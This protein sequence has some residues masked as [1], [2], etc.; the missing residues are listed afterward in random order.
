[1]WMY[2]Y[3]L[4]LTSVQGEWVPCCPTNTEGHWGFVIFADDQW[5]D[6]IMEVKFA[7]VIDQNDVSYHVAQI[8]PHM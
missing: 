7:E 2:T 4:M 5:L 8:D 6:R 1:M 3:S